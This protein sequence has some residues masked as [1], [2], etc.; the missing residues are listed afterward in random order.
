MGLGA[1]GAINEKI[2]PD[3]HGVETWDQ[4]NFAEVNVQILNTSQF[5]QI[6][7]HPPPTTSINEETYAENKFPWFP[8]YGETTQG[9][10]SPSEL[11]AKAKT[12]AE[13]DAERDQHEADRNSLS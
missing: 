11:L 3:P 1:G 13:R 7:G 9:D 10:V 6:T 5:Q 2:L 12:V 8:L 4:N